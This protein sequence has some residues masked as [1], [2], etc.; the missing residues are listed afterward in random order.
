[1]A[2]TA[3]KLKAAK[4]YFDITDCWHVHNKH[5]KTFQS[6]LS[7]YDGVDKENR[8]SAIA[9]HK[10]RTETARSFELLKPMI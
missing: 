1:M 9:L 5:A 10:C 4:S 8:I 7:R 2:F 3:D 6:S